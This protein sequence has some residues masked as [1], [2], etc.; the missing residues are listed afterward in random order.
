[1]LL[2]M[3]NG[4][5][6]V[7]ILSAFIPNVLARSEEAQATLQTKIAAASC[8]AGHFPGEGLPLVNPVSCKWLVMLHLI[9]DT[10]SV[11]PVRVDPP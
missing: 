7:P 8:K 10:S 9:S 2:T 6:P 11:W 1:M 4:G 5:Q 3:S